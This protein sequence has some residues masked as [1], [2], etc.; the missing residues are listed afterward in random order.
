M[1]KCTSI[2]HCFQ[3]Q[4]MQSLLFITPTW[5]PMQPQKRRK[6]M[7]GGGKEDFLGKNTMLALLKKIPTTIFLRTVIFLP[8]VM[9][10]MLQKISFPSFCS[11]V[12]LHHSEM[13]SLSDC[14]TFR[15]HHCQCQMT[16]VNL[17]KVRLCHF[18]TASLSVPNDSSKLTNGHEH[19]RW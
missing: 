12:R 4:S 3:P 17:H 6:K 2:L 10:H 8:F 9:T 5:S 18:L 14:V 7:F 19:C 11:E 16:P 1:S 15:L 13:V